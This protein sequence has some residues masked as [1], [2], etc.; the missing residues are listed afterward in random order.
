MAGALL[1]LA[2][3]TGEGR[4]QAIARE[5][6]E[7]FAGAHERFGPQA[8]PFGTVAGRLLRGTV[9]IDLSAPAGSDLHRA[10]LRLADHEAIVVPGIGATEEPVER[11][12]EFENDAAYVVSGEERS[13]PAYDPQTLSERVGEHL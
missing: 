9:R 10:A 2:E 4:Y 11:E 8:A 5:T 6:T 13:A 12:A 3:I 1:D 7:S